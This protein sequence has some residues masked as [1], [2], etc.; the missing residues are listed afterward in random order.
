MERKFNV[1]D[2]VYRD[3]ET[4]CFGPGR[5]KKVL[6]DGQVDVSWDIFKGTD[7]DVIGY[8]PADLVDDQTFWNR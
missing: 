6:P 4:A 2:I 8:Q 3:H 7:L 1:G 5:V